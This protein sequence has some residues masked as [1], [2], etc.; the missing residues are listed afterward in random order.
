[1][2]LRLVLFVLQ[3]R[4]VR[5]GQARLCIRQKETGLIFA[6]SQ[7]FRTG[8]KSPG[9]RSLLVAYAQAMLLPVKVR[10]LRQPC[11]YSRRLDRVNVNA[12]G[13]IARG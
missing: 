8:E 12:L 2:L 11:M 10:L 4:K 6:A 9:G 5:E 1:M 13:V 3:S 7:N